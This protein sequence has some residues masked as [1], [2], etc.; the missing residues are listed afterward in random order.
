MSFYLTA[1][2]MKQMFAQHHN[3]LS[4]FDIQEICKYISTQ[5][6]QNGLLA[7]GK[8]NTEI[9]RSKVFFIPIT[10]D[11]RWIY[12][13]LGEFVTESNKKHFG[14]D[15]TSLQ[16]I[17]YTEY[18]AEDAGTYDDHLDFA[19]LTFTPRKLSLSVQLSDDHEYSGGEL[20]LKLN[21]QAPYIASRLKGAGVLFPSWVLHGVTP[22]TRGVRKSLVVWAEG[23][24]W[25]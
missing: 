16:S 6:L 2:R 1:P 17:Q 13:K 23:P 8:T 11:T 12:N 18:H 25:R 3:V 21:S 24:E 5:E 10:T 20:E 9:R 7:N 19:P 15:V 22:V 14:I 4:N